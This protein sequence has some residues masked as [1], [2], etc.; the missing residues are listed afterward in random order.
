MPAANAKCEAF[1]RTLR[2]RK[3]SKCEMRTARRIS[4]AHAGTT[5]RP[6]PTFQHH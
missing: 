1:P 5:T 2:G 3:R 4:P 6:A